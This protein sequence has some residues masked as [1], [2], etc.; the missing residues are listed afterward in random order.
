MCETTPEEILQGNSHG[1]VDYEPK[2]GLEFDSDENALNFYNEYARR[3]GFSVRREYVNTNKKLGYVTSRKITCYK[4][5][6][7]RND[8]QKEQVKKSRRETRTGC[9]AHII[10]TRQSMGKYRITKVELEHNHS[11]VPPTMAHEIDLAASSGLFSKATFD[12][13]SLQAS[14]RV[15]LGYTKLDQKNYLRTKRQKAI[16]QGEAGVLVEY[17]EKK[18]IDDPSFFFCDS[19]MIIDYETFGDMLSFD[20]TYQTPLVFVGLNNHRKM[21]VFGVALMYDETSE[22][23]QWL[24]VWHMEQNATKHLNQIYKRYASFRGDFTLCIYVDEDEFIN[25]WNSMLGEYN[26]HENEWLQGIYALREKL[27]AAYGKNFFSGG[28]NSTQLSESLNGDLK[29]YLQSD[30]NIVQFFKHYDRA[31]KDKRYNELQDTCDASQRFP[32]LKAQVS[33]LAHAREVYTSHI[34]TYFQDE[35]MK[36]LSMK[37]NRC[38]END[39][40]IMWTIDAKAE[41]IKEVD[42][43]DIEIK[44]PKLITMNRYRVLCP[45][46]V[47]LAAKASET[48]DGY[49]E[50]IACANELS[51]KLKEIM[52]V[53]APSLCTSSS[54]KDLSEANNSKDILTQAK[55]LKKKDGTRRKKRDKGCLE[56]NANSKKALGNK[57]SR[58]NQIGLRADDRTLSDNANIFNQEPLCFNVDAH[59]QRSYSVPPDQANL[60]ESQGSQKF[61]DNNTL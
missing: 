13:M 16:R 45:I 60:F 22:S 61:Q 41:D 56:A 40:S 4:E 20:T 27:F 55:G 10:V 43:Q 52:K 7:R 11:L 36:S 30:Y 18:R 28:M 21:V 57:S 50:A 51:S 24:C 33:I 17:F 1:L 5:G 6:F 25:A 54:G 49:K 37:V 31:I 47:R 59:S 42:G 39:L 23:F 53:T 38:E 9:Q 32:V 15:N 34:F 2:L 58:V 46:F 29:D 14:G 3:V 8:K 26:L 12:F 19:K 44:D 35:Y 48:D